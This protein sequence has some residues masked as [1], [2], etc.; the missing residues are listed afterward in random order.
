[1]D[2]VINFDLPQVAEDYVH[3]IGRTG[4]AGAG[5]SAISLVS[6]DEA[7]QLRDIEKLIKQKIPVADAAKIDPMLARPV[8]A[9]SELFL[10]GTKP[11]TNKKSSS[12]SVRKRSGTNDSTK[13]KSSGIRKKST[14]INDN[15][16]KDHNEKVVN[17]KPR[18]RRN[19]KPSSIV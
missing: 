9:L 16:A 3:R 7:K 6:R 10:S 19:S 8:K 1:L 2:T 15:K 5:G 14:S 12:G 18:R 4:R 13:K 17:Q 11:R